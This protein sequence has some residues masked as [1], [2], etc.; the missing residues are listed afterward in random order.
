MKLIVNIACCLAIAAGISV[1][2]VPASASPARAM[3]HG[4]VCTQNASGGPHICL[5]AKNGRIG[6]RGTRIVGGHYHPGRAE[7]ITI[8]A[9]GECGDS[10]TVTRACPG[11]W[12]S[13]HRLGDLLATIRPASSASHCETPNIRRKLV[14]SGCH[15]TGVVYV[16]DPGNHLTNV[17]FSNRKHRAME[18]RTDGMPGDQITV[19]RPAGARSRWLH[20]G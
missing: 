10:G 1:S 20:S 12:I 11:G 14:I 13:S 18:V 9:S 16:L 7:N 19:G 17:H 6:T 8:F 3:L 5:K 15:T 2:L 4:P